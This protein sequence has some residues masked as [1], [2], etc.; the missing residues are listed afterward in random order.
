[1]SELQI[2]LRQSTKQTLAGVWQLLNADIAAT[3]GYAADFFGK[4]MS[5]PR[6]ISILLMPGVMCCALHRL[7]HWAWDRHWPG[8]AR[9]LARLNYVLHKADISPAASVG[10]GLYI[11]HTVGIMFHGK[12]GKS[13]TLYAYCQVSPERLNPPGSVR[14]DDAPLIG[15]GVTIGAYSI[16]IGSLILGDGV[17]IGPQVVVKQNVEAG[18]TLL[19]RSRVAIKARV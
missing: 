7:A 8:L 1:M 14:L 12:A 3:S 6:R 18:A 9:T 17:R 11:P 2:E 4:G 5:L 15:D 16:V 13:L 19:P 10:P